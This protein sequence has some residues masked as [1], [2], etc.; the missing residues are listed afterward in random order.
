MNA[1]A[2]PRVEL[3]R[4]RVFADAGITDAILVVDR[5]GRRIRAFHQERVEDGAKR[6]DSGTG[7]KAGD[8]P[9]TQGC[10]GVAEPLRDADA[11]RCACGERSQGVGDL[12]AAADQELYGGQVSRHRRNH[13]PARLTLCCRQRDELARRRVRKNVETVGDVDHDA[14]G[15]RG[16]DGAMNDPRGVQLNA[17]ERVCGGNYHGLVHGSG[18]T[19]RVR[20]QPTIG[21]RCSHS[22]HAT[23]L[24]HRRG[25][26]LPCA[27]TILVVK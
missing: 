25:G 8:R 20:R 1:G 10:H 11:N 3:C 15:P 21:K 13:E 9:A 22:M 5:E 24:T 27:H 26:L 17:Q 23:P 12:R 2:S 4:E 16:L 18:S 14:G 19:Q 6:R 7:R